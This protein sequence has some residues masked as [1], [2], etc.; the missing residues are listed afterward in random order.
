[1]VKKGRP[2]FVPQLPRRARGGAKE[3]R[4]KRGVA[5]ASGQK[6]GA[7]FQR[8]RRQR[9]FAVEPRPKPDLSTPPRSA[10]TTLQ[11]SD[12]EVSVAPP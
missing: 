6:T 7:G 1:M 11:R 3:R 5:L 9:T 10:A 4:G 12:G 2:F 8:E